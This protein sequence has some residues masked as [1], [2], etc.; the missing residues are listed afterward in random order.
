MLV[1]ENIKKLRPRQQQD[2]IWDKIIYA[3]PTKPRETL[4]ALDKYKPLV[5]YDNITELQRS[6]NTRRTPGSS[7][8]CA[9]PTPA[10][11]WSFPRNSA[12]IRAKPWI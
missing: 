1:Y 8:G 9:C 2:F 3:N 7:C 5:T 10:P 11:W 4:Q 6:G 12:V